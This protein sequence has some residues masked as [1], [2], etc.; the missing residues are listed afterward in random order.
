M[1][2]WSAIKKHLIEIKK[3]PALPANCVW[4][5]VKKKQK[6]ILY[7]SGHEGGVPDVEYCEEEHYGIY[8]SADEKFDHFLGPIFVK[9]S[10]N[11][12]ETLDNNNWVVYNMRSKTIEE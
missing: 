2:F 6:T 4:C 12:F 7:L 1:K 3:D 8:L 5:K 11:Q 9:V 10:K